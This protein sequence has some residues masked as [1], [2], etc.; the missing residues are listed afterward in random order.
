MHTNDNN[1]DETNINIPTEANA[2]AST[3]PT[4]DRSLGAWLKITSRLLAVERETLF[5]R[6]GVTRRD[7]RILNFVS[8]GTPAHPRVGGPK[9]RKLVDR[10]WIERN[11]GEWTLTEDGQAL[12]ARLTA[13]MNGLSST[14]TEALTT[15]EMDTTLASLRKASRALGWDDS[16]PLPRRPHRG[17]RR[18]PHARG[19]WARRGHDRHFGHR[20][21]QGHPLFGDQ[22]H[23]DGQGCQTHRAGQFE[24]A[25]QPHPH[26]QGRD[27]WQGRPAHPGHRRFRMAQQVFERGFDAGFARG[28]R[29]E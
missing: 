29:A 14:M 26:H 28:R 27:G 3:D 10:G 4:A 1:N 23:D 6:E 20:F 24:E 22:R 7:W 9:L 19:G 17:P 2:D 5:A 25:E 15:E 16:S 12:L 11:E 8:R 18:G 21:D 13:G